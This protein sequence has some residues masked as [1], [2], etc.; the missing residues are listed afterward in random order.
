M[1]LPAGAAVLPQVAEG[2]ISYAVTGGE[3]SPWSMR[4]AP[5]SPAVPEPSPEALLAEPD[6]E[7]LHGCILERVERP[8]LEAVLRETEGNQIRAAARLGINRNTLRKK[9]A[10]LSV[11]LPRRP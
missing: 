1:H 3:N 11:R 2:T 4:I 5:L 6:S 8:L 7:G 9:I 10:E